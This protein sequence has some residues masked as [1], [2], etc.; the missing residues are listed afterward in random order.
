MPFDRQKSQLILDRLSD[1]VEEVARIATKPL[2]PLRG[3]KVVRD[4]RK[5]TVSRFF[6]VEIS[7]NGEKERVEAIFV[8]GEDQRPEIRNDP[9]P[10]DDSEFR[11]LAKQ[12]IQPLMRGN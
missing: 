6:R 12:L 11:E 3:L 8:T 10:R 9:I 4:G 5:V 2:G 1:E 7:V